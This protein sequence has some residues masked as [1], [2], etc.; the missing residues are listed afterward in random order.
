[1]GT[2]SRSGTGGDR[3]ATEGIGRPWILKRA[4]VS[5]PSGEW[6]EEIMKT[7][8][9]RMGMV[10]ADHVGGALL[11]SG[12]SRHGGSNSIKP[13]NVFC[14]LEVL[15]GL[16]SLDCAIANLACAPIFSAST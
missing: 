3:S 12:T 13:R 11:T 14:R 2:P 6:N 7:A 1:M 15:S 4:S 8:R 5:R 16:A 9:R 10:G